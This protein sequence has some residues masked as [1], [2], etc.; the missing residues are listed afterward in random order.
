MQCKYLKD[1]VKY[2]LIDD[3]FHIEKI[4]TAEN[5]QQILRISFLMD[6]MDQLMADASTETYAT[7]MNFMFELLSKLMVYSTIDVM[8]DM[9]HL[10]NVH[11]T[12][13]Q[14]LRFKACNFHANQCL[15][16]TDDKF[17]HVLNQLH[18]NLCH[19]NEPIYRSLRDEMEMENKIGQVLN[20]FVME[21]VLTSEERYLSDENDRKIDDDTEEEMNANQNTDKFGILDFGDPFEHWNFCETDEI[22]E[23]E[24]YEPKFKSVVHLKELLMDE[25][26]NEIVFKLKENFSIL[27]V[28]DIFKELFTVEVEPE[29]EEIP[30]SFTDVSYTSD[31]SSEH[32]VYFYILYRE[33]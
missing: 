24:K 26:T 16:I 2:A 32:E 9:R 17:G 22:K 20:R 19:K 13:S 12:E 4:T 6:I 25:N 8:N 5:C 10:Q 21:T 28:C 33:T 3:N 18:I 27:E 11:C 14:K 7:C 23:E 15:F 1:T 29:V 31:M 30:R